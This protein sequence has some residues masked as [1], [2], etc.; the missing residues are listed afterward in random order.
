[1]STGCRCWY[2]LRGMHTKRKKTRDVVWAPAVGAGT[3]HDVHLQ[4][5]NKKPGD[6]VSAPSV[7]AGTTYGVG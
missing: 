5:K 4:N 7:G 1:M 3:T 2:H 6:V